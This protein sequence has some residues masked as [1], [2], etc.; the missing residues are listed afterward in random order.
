MGSASEFLINKLALDKGKVK[1]NRNFKYKIYPFFTREPERAQFTNG[2]K[3]IL[4]AISRDSLELKIDYS[5]KDYNIENIYNNVEAVSDLSEKDKINFLDKVFGYTNIHAIN[6]PYLVNYYP[7]TNGSEKT[8]E[9]NIAQYISSI[10]DLRQ[11]S[12]W[13][14]FIGDKKAKNLVEKILLESIDEIPKVENKNPFKVILN[15][16]LKC[17][18]EDLNYLL[19]HKEFA[20][21]NIDKFFAFYYFQYITQTILN[22]NNINNLKYGTHLYPLYFTL[23][24]EKLTSSRKTNINGYNQITSLK[25]F[26]LI[27]DNL[28]GYLND[29]INII[30]NDEKFYTLTEILS[31]PSNKIV[32]LNNELKI[33]LSNYKIINKKNDELSDELITNIEI[34]KKWLSE[35]IN[36]ETISRYHLSVEDIG[37]YMFLKNRGSLGKTLTLK[38]EMLILLTAVIIK[39]EK[40]LIKDVFLEFEKRGVYFDRYTREE[41]ALFYE[42]MNILDK[43]SDSGDVKYVKSVL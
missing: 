17:K 23:E 41:I 4:G 25:N 10:F 32:Q 42:K 39:E 35:D 18:I 7:L 19:D 40:M 12:K 26:T 24:T 8:G 1:Y 30:N 14:Q 5:S 31:L 38:K 43:K 11:N 36:K 3:P 6:H 15:D 2:F 34:F 22:L 16:E 21:K 29:L 28:L 9:I 37:R 33:V 27:N 20:L 13:C